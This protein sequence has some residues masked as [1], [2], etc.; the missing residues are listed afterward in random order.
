MNWY[1][2]FIDLANESY[3]YLLQKHQKERDDKHSVKF[4]L[5]LNEFSHIFM[6]YICHGRE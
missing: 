1:I 5:N 3:L 4:L 6:E 2:Q